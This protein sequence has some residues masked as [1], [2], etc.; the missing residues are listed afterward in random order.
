MGKGIMWQTKCS[1]CNHS[2]ARHKKCYDKDRLGRDYICSFGRC[3]C[4][5]CE[6]TDFVAEVKK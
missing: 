5:N 2:Q 4:K 6:C 1:N 3:L